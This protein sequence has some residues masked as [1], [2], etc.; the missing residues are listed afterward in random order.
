MVKALQISI[1]APTRG[2]T[3]SICRTPA[4]RRISIHAPARGATIFRQNPIWYC[5]ISIHAPARGATYSCQRYADCNVFQSTLP[6]GE[7]PNK[8]C[9]T[10]PVFVFQSTLPRGERRPAWRRII[11]VRNFNPRSR[12]GSDARYIRSVISPDISIHAPA[13][14]AT[15]Y[16][17][18]SPSKIHISIHA[19]ARGA[20][21]IVDP[22]VVGSTT[23]SIHAPARGATIVWAIHMLFM[24][25]FNP[26]SREGS[27]V[28]LRFY[29]FVAH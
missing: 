9:R 14:G 11:L 1:H 8:L 23:I 15:L 28:T 3:R 26:R 5:P 13:R 22:G 7:R 16:G 6:R 18:L 20:T 25:D 2:A 19:P 21:V 12:E 24:C 27:D 4:D 10:W 29:E 17:L